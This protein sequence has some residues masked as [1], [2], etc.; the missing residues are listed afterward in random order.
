[1]GQRYQAVSAVTHDGV[2]V[3]EVA[4]R[5]EVSRQSVHA[6]LARCEKAALADRSH[7]PKACA[8]QMPASVEALVLEL[9]RRNP[10]WSPRVSPLPS[11]SGI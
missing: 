6:G 4:R 9:R 1:M 7:R 10:G 8:H 3:V 11:R 5:F 2:S